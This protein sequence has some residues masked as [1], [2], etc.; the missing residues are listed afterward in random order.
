MSDTPH[1]DIR[2]HWRI[3]RRTMYVGVILTV[4][5]SIAFM[6]IGYV[7][8]AALESMGV[9]ISWVYGT[10]TVIIIGYY[11]NTAVSDYVKNRKQ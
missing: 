6:W 2:K 10:L 9:L 5:F 1:P 4:I 7:N 11:G 3:R 8:P